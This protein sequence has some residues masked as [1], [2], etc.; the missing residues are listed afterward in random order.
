MQIPKRI[1]QTWK[2]STVPDKWRPS[3]QSIQKFCPDWEYRLTTDEQNR[4]FVK[5]IFPQY[6]ELY[7]SFDREIYRVDIVRYLLLYSYGGVY[8]DLDLELIRPLEELLT[9]DSDLYLVRTPNLGGYTNAF[10]APA[11]GCPFWLE[12]ISEIAHRAKY[13]PW[14]IQGDLKVLW[15]TG[16]QMITSVISRYNRPFMTI[17]YRLGHPCS[18]CDNYNGT[19]D[20]SEAYVRELE[21][22]SW[23]GSAATVHYIMCCWETILAIVVLLLIVFLILFGGLI[24]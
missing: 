8:I 20:L 24:R 9:G 14:Y 4:N 11:P 15:T 13:R 17:P 3:P 23:S 18:I 1:W 21:G 7:Q 10:M 16:P 19:G 5:Q 6:Y 2:T 12:C 22:S